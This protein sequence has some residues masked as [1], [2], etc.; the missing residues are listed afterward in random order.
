MQPYLLAAVPTQA[1]GR[2]LPPPPSLVGGAECSQ[3]GGNPPFVAAVTKALTDGATA[4]SVA[5]SSLPPAPP[6]SEAAPAGSPI[7]ESN[8]G[9]LQRAR[10][11][12]SPDRPAASLATTDAAGAP[13]PGEATRNANPEGADHLMGMGEGHGG[14]RSFPDQAAA[15]P[16]STRQQT[17]MSVPAPVQMAAGVD[18]QAGAAS[19]AAAM[20][21]ASLIG[22]TS[23]QTERYSSHVLVAAR[24]MPGQKTVTTADVTA[25]AGD[26]AIPAPL[27]QDAGTPANPV[28][29]AAR[30]DGSALATQGA[31]PATRLT[32][33][34]EAA[35]QTTPPGGAAS[36]YPTDGPNTLTEPGIEPEPP[37][38]GTSQTVVSAWPHSAV[39]AR[40]DTATGDLARPHS[41][42]SAAETRAAEMLGGQTERTK[43]AEE[44]Q[45]NNPRHPTEMH[46]AALVAS[47]PSTATATLSGVGT[48][49]D[50]PTMPPHAGATTPAEPVGMD[51][52]TDRATAVERA[53]SQSDMPP[54][55]Q[56]SGT[57]LPSPV[58][59]AFTSETTSASQRPTSPTAEPSRRRSPTEQIT[60]SLMQIRRAPNGAQTLT[61]R[62]DPPELGHVQV[63]IDR[64]PDAP[65]R[66]EIVV[67]KPETL[68]MLLRDQAQ[69]Q[70]AL[71]Q[72]G[73]PA[74]GRN[75]TFHVATPEPSPRNDSGTAPVPNT[76][77]G[78][79]A[80]DGSH[81][82]AR[83]HTRSGRRHHDATDDGGGEF[84]PINPSS[85][86]RAGLD[87]TA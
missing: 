80:G 59:V 68:N 70:R 82:T 3:T 27:G 29:L 35:G 19:A 12:S 64:S 5:G 37:A 78:G 21:P 38:Y 10:Y 46:V 86:M 9:A 11:V 65:A 73:V 83:Q 55:A 25:I 32:P 8:L 7:L 23:Q 84:T 14:G 58:A 67:E 74:E 20:H 77:A 39:S 22:A 85:W 71:D 43:P 52:L 16:E 36:L 63:K 49:A 6:S 33:G 26:T 72:A 75:V 30:S 61:V 79:F 42:V 62:L 28:P 15:P 44:V 54:S 18:D 60:P 76:I 17:S 2:A 34:S 31:S 69:L 40:S 57:P 4:N 1:V 48:Q 51:T 53:V 13:T 41:T 45:A 50:N 66:V 56:I 81:G 87:I 47:T 24:K